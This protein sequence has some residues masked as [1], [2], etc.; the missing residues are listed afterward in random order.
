MA[1]FG[2]RP[3]ANVDPGQKAKARIYERGMTL[4]QFAELNNISYRVVSEVVRG[5]NKGLYG[6]GHRAAVALGLKTGGDN[7]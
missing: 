7:E 2:G 3:S 6:E 1:S 5:V 4:K